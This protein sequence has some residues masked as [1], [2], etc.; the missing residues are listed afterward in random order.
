MSALSRLGRR[1]RVAIRSVAP[2][3]E[4][5]ADVAA[6]TK[7]RRQRAAS[8]VAKDPTSALELIRTELEGDRPSRSAAR[9][10][11]R[12]AIAT[13]DT[14]LLGRLGPHLLDDPR[15]RTQH[16]LVTGA[17]EAGLAELASRA[18]ERLAGTTPQYRK[19][20]RDAATLMR[21]RPAVEV[22][23]MIAR[24]RERHPALDLEPLTTAWDERRLAEAEPTDLE[25][26]AASVLD[27]H[28]ASGAVV[29]RALDREHAWPFLSTL[30]AD[31]PEES[32]PP[33]DAGWAKRAGRRAARAGWEDVS[34]ALARLGL[35]TKP[36]SPA[37]LA[38]LDS[39]QAVLTIAQDG[40]SV[41][42]RAPE[43][44]GEVDPQVIVSVLGQ[45][46]PLR[47]GG[48]ATRSHGVLTSMAAH[49]WT[50]QAITKWGFPYDLWWEPDDPREVPSVDVVDSIPYHR[51]LEPGRRSYPR[52]PLV[53]T[54]EGTARGVE[55]L[56]REHGAGLVHA[57][58]LYDVG[59]GALT[60]ARRLGIPFIYEMRG[61][62]QLLDEDRGPGVPPSPRVQYLDVLESTVAREADALLVITQAL[63]DRM[64]GFGVDPERIVV[65]SNGV[66]PDRFEPR[67]RDS[68]LEA[69]LGLEGLSVIGYVGSFVRYEGLDDLLLAAAEL[70]AAGRDDFRVLLVG[71]G[72]SFD[73]VQNLATELGIA[74]RVIFTGRVPHDQVDRYISLID[75][76]PFPRK[77]MLVC[78]MISPIKP[79]E[80]MAM[81]KAV[82]VSDVAALAEIVQDGVTGRSFRKGDVG[83]LA[84]VLAELLDDPDQRRRLGETA[85]EWVLEHRT[86]SRVTQAV[87]TTY[88]RLLGL[89]VST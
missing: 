15:T 77:P 51:N 82:V 74:D 28:P 64:V 83:A 46:L 55:A 79:F 88:R 81:S 69:S 67:P 54:V 3:G 32:W 35:R 60:A 59:L 56:V 57:S 8:I 73:R 37:L 45:S 40:W 11:L 48:Y 13:D 16:M 49:G 26:L 44:Y 75:I 66:H 18:E 4:S 85:R 30:L 70:V 78:E 76:A 47:S 10:G 29:L 5:A 41:P 33:V 20:V 42:P 72:G 36:R 27:E 22:E 61:L 86:W 89:P 38:L 17:R 68:E 14:A 87:D 7:E 84:A 1:I 62:K 65:V 25:A 24:V 9:T 58:S 50:M 19:E 53:E 6:A 71:D 52:H 34:V 12:A 23:A 31:R 2:A 21:E 39:S 43:P 80:S 63:G